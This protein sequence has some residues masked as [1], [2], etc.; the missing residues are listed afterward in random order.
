LEHQVQATPEP[1]NPEE[2]DATS[3]VDDDLVVSM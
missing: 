1:A 2:I 3:G